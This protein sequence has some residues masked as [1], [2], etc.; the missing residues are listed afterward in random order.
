MKVLADFKELFDSAQVELHE[1]YE[2]QQGTK[3]GTPAY[4]MESM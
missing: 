3:I 1:A 4:L 2:K